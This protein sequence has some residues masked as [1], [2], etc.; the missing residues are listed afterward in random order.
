VAVVAPD[1]VLGSIRS[2]TSQEYL[3]FEVPVSITNL[4]TTTAKM[5]WCGALHLERNIGDDW[6]YAWGQACTLP[7]GMRPIEIAAGATRQDTVY[8]FSKYSTAGQLLQGTYRVAVSLFSDETAP[9]L[10]SSAPF[11]LSIAPE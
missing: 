10:K 2:I 1:S 6:H 5:N 8:V 9:S 3:K 7:G 4:G 11:S